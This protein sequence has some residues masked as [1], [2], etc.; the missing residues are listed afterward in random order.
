[1]TTG[2]DPQVMIARPRSFSGSDWG[3]GGPGKDRQ[4]RLRLI[5]TAWLS[6]NRIVA[7]LMD[8]S[9]AQGFPRVRAP[10]PIST[11]PATPLVLGTSRSIFA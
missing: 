8:G 10:L 11:D 9:F 2:A 4:S 6:G 5:C 1:M 3:D 7:W